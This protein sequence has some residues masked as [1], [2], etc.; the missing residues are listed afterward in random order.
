MAVGIASSV[1]QFSAAQ[2][3]YQAR[4]EQWR[5]NVV[6]SWAAAREEQK[7]LLARELQ[8][9][10]AYA[11]KSHLSLVEQAEKQ[12][13]AEVSAAGAGV[14]G[15]SVGN[16]VADIG[17][18][19]ATNRVLAERNW[20]NTAQQLRQ[21]QGATVTRASNRINSVSVPTSPSSAG[22]LAGIGG[23]A[24]KAFGTSFDMS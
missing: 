12:A 16:L 11:Q 2:S 1:A 13:T 7:Q 9:Q 22:L 10:E 21:E 4:A 19:A 18:K 23:S 20:M 17:R 24:I 15:I 8:E 6:N 5:S 3:D 14:S